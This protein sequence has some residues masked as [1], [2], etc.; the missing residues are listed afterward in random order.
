MQFASKVILNQP[1]TISKSA[2][3][4]SFINKPRQFIINLNAI[5]QAARHKLQIESKQRMRFLP[6]MQTSRIKTHRSNL[7]NQISKIWSIYVIIWCPE[8]ASRH[9]RKLDVVH[10]KKLLAI[11]Y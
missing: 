1:D 5:L 2:N 11:K 8:N 10:N 4:W 3:T 9:S 7:R 6:P